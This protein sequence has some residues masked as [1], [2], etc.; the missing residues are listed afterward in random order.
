MFYSSQQLWLPIRLFL[1]I[2]K[3]LL[4]DLGLKVSLSW[5][6]RLN[7]F[8]ISINDRCNWIS[9]HIPALHCHP[10]LQT[11]WLSFYQHYEDLVEHGQRRT[12]PIFAS[13]LRTEWRRRWEWPDGS[14]EGIKSSTCAVAHTQG[15]LL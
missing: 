10:W 15:Y 5:I 11:L 2:K 13:F 7:L 12:N 14:D 9:F 4:W 8:M 1:F 6:K 3:Q